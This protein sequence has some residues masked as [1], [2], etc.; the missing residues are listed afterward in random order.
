[1]KQLEKEVLKMTT[2]ER[3]DFIALI[4]FLRWR[5]LGGRKTKV[6]QRGERVHFKVIEFT[7]NAVASH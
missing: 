4:R 1:M 5:E 2:K 7:G 6:I 3:N